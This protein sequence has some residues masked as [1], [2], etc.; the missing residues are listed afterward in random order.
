MDQRTNLNDFSKRVSQGTF[1]AGIMAKKYPDEFGSRPLISENAP[2]SRRD[3]FGLIL[4]KLLKRI[5][6]TWPGR[7]SIRASIWLLD[8]IAPNSQLMRN[9][10]WKWCGIWI[11]VGVRDGLRFR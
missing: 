8:H 3:G 4:K 5:V 7:T 1:T 2:A 10:Y 9:A 6:A 11:H